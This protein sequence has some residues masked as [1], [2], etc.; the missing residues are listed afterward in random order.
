MASSSGKPRV[1]N[2]S[3]ASLDEQSALLAAVFKEKEKRKLS[4]NKKKKAAEAATRA[5]TQ[6]LQDGDELSV[7]DDPLNDSQ[8]LT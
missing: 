1:T 5:S 7:Q 4:K 8:E 2:N 6:R 3:V